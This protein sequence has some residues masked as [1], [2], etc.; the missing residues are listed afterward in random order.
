[1]HS[2]FHSVYISTK[3]APVQQEGVRTLHSTLFIL[4]RKG[5]RKIC[6]NLKLYIPLCLYQYGIKTDS[7]KRLVVSTFHS[8]YISTYFLFVVMDSNHLYIPLC[9]YQYKISCVGVF[10]TDTLY[11]P[12]CLYQYCLEDLKLIFCSCLYIPLCLYQYVKDAESLGISIDSTFHSVY[13]STISLSCT[14]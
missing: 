14:Y 11:I 12:L 3:V 6:W 9:L 5:V 13:I 4:V 2:T 7:Q 1:M 10:F 8:V